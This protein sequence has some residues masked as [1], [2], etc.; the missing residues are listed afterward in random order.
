MYYLYLLKCSDESL[1]TGIT[2]DI[3]K[4][5][6]AHKEG[7]GSK[8]VYSRL[9]FT[10]VYVEEVGNRSEA[11]KREYEVKSWSREVKISELDLN[12]QIN[13]LDKYCKESIFN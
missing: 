13:L 9:P 8:Y 11:S 4:R 12:L 7:E 5:M 2:T 1:Y 10:L 6:I 3:G